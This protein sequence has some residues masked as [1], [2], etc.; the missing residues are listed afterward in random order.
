MFSA[1]RDTYVDMAVYSC[2]DVFYLQEQTKKRS[3][4]HL[5]VTVDAA[6]TCTARTHPSPVASKFPSIPHREETHVIPYI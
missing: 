4:P 6:E 2:L 1:A 5:A 3:V